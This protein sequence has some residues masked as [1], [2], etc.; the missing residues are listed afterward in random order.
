VTLQ[1]GVA[2]GDCSAMEGGISY[3]KWDAAL[4]IFFMQRTVQA[5]M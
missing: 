1:H 4:A 2:C 3:W 5:G